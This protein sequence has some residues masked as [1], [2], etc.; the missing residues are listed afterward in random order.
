[1]PG[2]SVGKRSELE[3]QALWNQ[4]QSKRILEQIQAQSRRNVAQMD[5]YRLFDTAYE[6]IVAKNNEERK[7]RNREK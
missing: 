4:Y 6:W 1:M 7:E 2:K 5:P 3:K